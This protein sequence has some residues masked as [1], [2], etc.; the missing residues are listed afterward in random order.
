M[1]D[2][3]TTGEAIDAL[4]AHAAK[5]AGGIVQETV[6]P[7][8]GAREL[9]DLWSALTPLEEAL[10]VFVGHSL[11]WDELPDKRDALSQA[12]VLDADRFLGRWGK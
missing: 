5:I 1:P 10:R 11:Q 3:P 9:W 7:G 4:I 2:D 8:R 12:I 6:S